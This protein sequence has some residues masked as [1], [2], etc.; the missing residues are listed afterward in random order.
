MEGQDYLEDLY[1]GEV[2]QW[3]LVEGQWGLGV[4]WVGLWDLG[5]QWEDQWDLEDLWAQWDQVVQWVLEGQWADLED[6]WD[7]ENQGWS[8]EVKTNTDNPAEY[9]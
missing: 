6:R 2:L 5:D 8:V 9:G 4:Q 1:Q 7:Q 3:D